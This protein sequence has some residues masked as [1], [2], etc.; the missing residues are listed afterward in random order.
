MAEYLLK[1]ARKL[2]KESEEKAEKYY[3]DYQLGGS[4]S[5]YKTYVKYDEMAEICRHAIEDITN[6]DDK[7]RRRSVAYSHFL[8]DIPKHE[9]FTR[10]EVVEL[11]E[12]TRYL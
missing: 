1:A 6:E 5:S 4:A 10:A 8:Q 3:T 2:L 7:A 11:I 12:K 9:R